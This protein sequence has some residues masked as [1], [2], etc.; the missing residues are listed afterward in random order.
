MSKSI[1]E[2]DPMDVHIS[3][4]ASASGGGMFQAA[5]NNQKFMAKVT[6]LLLADNKN[7]NTLSQGLSKML[8]K[9]K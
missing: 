4:F 7:N 3:K 8:G 5:M 1:N 6:K 2:K 9:S